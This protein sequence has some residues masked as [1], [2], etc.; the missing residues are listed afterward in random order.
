MV[1][2][3]D[4][5]DENDDDDDGDCGHSLAIALGVSTRLLERE[6]LRACVGPTLPPDCSGVPALPTAADPA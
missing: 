4:D 3:D 5:D 1:D 6:C 2:E